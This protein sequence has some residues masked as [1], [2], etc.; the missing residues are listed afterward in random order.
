MEKNKPSVFSDKSQ[1]F[2]N[3]K[4]NVCTHN[5]PSKPQFLLLATVFV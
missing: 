2:F 4:E 3:Q 5:Q 1:I